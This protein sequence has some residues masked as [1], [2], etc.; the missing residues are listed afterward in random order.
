MTMATITT[1][2]FMHALDQPLNVLFTRNIY[3]FHSSEN[4]MFELSHTLFFFF[5]FKVIRSHS[6]PLNFGESHH[7][8]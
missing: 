2:Q 8:Q 3:S 1:I 7:Y 5:F 4:I 6:Q